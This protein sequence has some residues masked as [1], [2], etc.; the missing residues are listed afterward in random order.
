[1]GIKCDPGVKVYGKGE[2]I[3]TLILLNQNLQ[4]TGFSSSYALDLK[5]AIDN[6]PLKL[7]ISSKLCPDLSLCCRCIY[8]HFSSWTLR[9]D[10]QNDNPKALQ[11]PQI[12]RKDS[13]I[14][15][16]Q[17]HESRHFRKFAESRPN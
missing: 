12:P 7:E 6:K 13:I 2:S 11:E 9:T 16:R 14:S 17:G 8:L 15:L 4:L 1:M 5:E 10:V 3:V